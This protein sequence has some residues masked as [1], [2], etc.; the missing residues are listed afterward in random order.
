MYTGYKRREEEWD[1][2]NFRFIN[3]YVKFSHAVTHSHAYSNTY[4]NLYKKSP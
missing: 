4:I 3:D 1:K 2:I